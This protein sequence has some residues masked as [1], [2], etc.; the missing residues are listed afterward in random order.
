[1][2]D[3]SVIKEIVNEYT[4]DYTEFSLYDVSWVK[5]F[6]Y[7][8]LQILV[9]KKGGINS[10]ELGVINEFISQR[11]DKYESDLPQNYMLEVSSP[12]AEKPLRNVDEVIEAVGEK[13]HVRTDKEE[14]EGKLLSFVDNILLISINVKGRIKKVSVDYSSVLEIRLAV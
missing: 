4:K 7:N 1:M 10:D 8:I 5:D 9:D 2:L 3:L 12:G 14:Y 11:L 13:I 6:G